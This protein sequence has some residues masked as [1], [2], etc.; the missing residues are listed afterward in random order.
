MFC[1]NN[2]QLSTAIG[3]LP[4]SS[5]TTNSSQLPKVRYGAFF[6]SGIVNNLC[7]EEDEQA[8][9][10]RKNLKRLNNDE[11]KLIVEEKRGGGGLS[12]RLF[13]KLIRLISV[14][15]IPFLANVKT[16]PSRGESN[17]VSKKMAARLAAA[18]RRRQHSSQ[19]STLS[20]S[21]EPMPTIEEEN[22]ENLE[23]NE[24]LIKEFVEEIIL[25]NKKPFESKQIKETTITPTTIIQAVA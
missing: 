17:N 12:R 2:H 14:K 7:K 18:R 3:C 13:G 24:L 15:E 16:F 8:F 10:K 1:P 4:T 6:S 5:C 11:N 19:S 21:F 23:N 9:S 20:G 22:E 25:N